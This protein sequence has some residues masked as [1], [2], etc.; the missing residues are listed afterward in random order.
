MLCAFSKIIEQQPFR[1]ESAALAIRAWLERVAP[2]VPVADIKA[3]EIG[4]PTG[5]RV[6]VLYRGPEAL[7]ALGLEPEVG[8]NILLASRGPG[9]PGRMTIL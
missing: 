8:P 7:P 4:R 3:C 5:M 1:M 6:P 9:L 2:Q